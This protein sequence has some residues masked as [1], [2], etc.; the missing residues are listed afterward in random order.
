M[1]RSRRLPAAVAFVALVT[2]LASPSGADAPTAIGWWYSGNVDG[3][4][5][6]A[7]PP[8]VPDGGLYVAG[9]LNG[10]SGVSALR[11]TLPDGA[12]SPVLT[13]EVASSSGTPVVGACPATTA[14]EPAAGGPFTDRPTPDCERVA[15]GG[16][17]S[18]DGTTLTIDLAPLVDGGAIDVVVLP[19]EDPTTGAGAVFELALQPPGDAALTYSQPASGGPVPTTPPATARPASPTTSVLPSAPPVAPP[20]PTPTTVPTAAAARFS[21]AANVGPPTAVPA[22]GT[23]TDT[24]D[25]SETDG[26]VV[27]VIL[28]VVVVTTWL[29]LTR[30]VLG[31]RLTALSG[32][33]T[34][35]VRGIGR[36][37]R[38]RPTDPPSL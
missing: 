31:A 8:D 37:A 17:L 38:P 19:G 34:D 13:L 30:T 3:L 1:S 7:P 36:Y 9:G 25:P 18:A 22:A 12:G 4:P 14:W 32:G 6:Q 23:D 28:V 21:P 27:A 16:E 5:V 15:V 24:D 20:T 33:T 29:L 2:V 10:A 26:R 35:D 11:F